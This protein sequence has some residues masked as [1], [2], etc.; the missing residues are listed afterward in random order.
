MLGSCAPAVIS[1]WWRRAPAVP[2]AVLGPA[3]IAASGPWASSFLIGLT[4]SA[5]ITLAW[6]ALLTRALRRRRAGPWPGRTR[7]QRAL[8]RPGVALTVGTVVVATACWGSLWPPNPAYHQWR[9][10]HGSVY[11][12]R[13]VA[14]D[15]GRSHTTYT[16]ATMGNQ[17]Y[18]LVE[19][20]SHRDISS[21]DYLTMRCEQVSGSPSP[22][23]FKCRVNA[24]TPNP[25]FAA[26]LGQLDLAGMPR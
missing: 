8:R 26:F 14:V 11:Y 22:F 20:S 19:N 6:C 1:T 13:A 24:D 15:T 4:I 7:L 9:L 16:V 17:K 2:S 23:A 25:A 18:A 12:T 21:G 5:T 3:Q 10:A